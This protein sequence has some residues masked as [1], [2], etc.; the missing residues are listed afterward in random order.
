MIRNLFLA[1]LFTWLIHIGYWV[2]LAM[3]AKKLRR[4]ERE[5]LKLEDK[6]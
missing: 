1:Y 2:S 3:R 6:R 4:E 5:L